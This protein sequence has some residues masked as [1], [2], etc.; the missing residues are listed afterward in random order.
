M[1]SSAQLYYSLVVF[2]CRL[3]K[4]YRAYFVVFHTQNYGLCLLFLFID[5]DGRVADHS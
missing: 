3:P 5:Y 2:R 1:F 4:V